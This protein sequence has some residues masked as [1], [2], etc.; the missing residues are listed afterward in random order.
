MLCGQTTQCLS[1]LTIKLSSR[2]LF[3]CSYGQLQTLDRLEGVDFGAG[4]SFLDGS[5][6]VH[7]DVKLA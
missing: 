6:S 1:N 4:S 3:P 5:I 7:G 2:G